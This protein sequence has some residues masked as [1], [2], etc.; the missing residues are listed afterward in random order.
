MGMQLNGSSP[1]STYP[2]PYSLVT[3]NELGNTRMFCPITKTPSFFEIVEAR[4][5]REKP[6]GGWTNVTLR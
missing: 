4:L 5:Q 2:S 1:N 6:T 3:S